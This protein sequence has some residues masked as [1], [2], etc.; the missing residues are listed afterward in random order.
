MC[1]LVN[2]DDWTARTAPPT[3]AWATRSAVNVSFDADRADTT[4]KE[5][6]VR[7]R[8]P[9]LRNPGRWMPI[10]HRLVNL[11]KE[12]TVDYVHRP[13]HVILMASINEARYQAEYRAEEERK[14]NPDA[15]LPPHIPPGRPHII[16][17]FPLRPPMEAVKRRLELLRQKPLPLPPP[18]PP[19][20]TLPVALFQ[21]SWSVINDYCGFLCFK[22]GKT[23]EFPY[24][25]R[26]AYRVNRATV[27]KVYGLV[28]RVMDYMNAL[29]IELDKDE[30]NVS[31]L[32]EALIEALIDLLNTLRHE[33]MPADKI[34]RVDAAE[35]QQYITGPENK[36]LL[37][38][39]QR[40]IVIIHNSLAKCALHIMSPLFKPSG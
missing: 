11:N 5:P 12:P 17:R 26:S 25:V 14:R 18:P 20:K 1:A 34:W 6:S 9:P 37:T 4:E 29:V 10:N 3:Y 19:P 24:I 36:D 39:G 7:P 33:G 13:P 38:T 2:G 23:H 35:M 22:V 28:V 16:N 30:P 40:Q 32:G 15:P 27:R 21:E 8:P 31:G